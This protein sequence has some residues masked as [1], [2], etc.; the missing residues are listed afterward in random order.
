MPGLGNSAEF[1]FGNQILTGSE[2][3]P[4]FR[5]NQIL[6]T[7]LYGW[8]EI[9]DIHSREQDL[10]MTNPLYNTGDACYRNNCQRCV[11]AYEARRRGYDVHAKPYLFQLAD[12][13]PYDDGESGWP[14]V[15]ENSK[16]ECCGSND[17]ADVKYNIHNKMVSWGEGSRAIVA[18]DFL[19]GGGHVF[20]AE[21]RNGR[22]H[23]MDPQNG[24]LDCEDYFDDINTNTA[25]ILRV[26]NCSFTNRVRE[27][28]EGTRHD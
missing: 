5:Q 27:C 2:S 13:L 17:S 26:D 24:Q 22:V 21:Y 28:C 11:V 18:V 14:S 3:M 7:N 15:F 19:L 1:T 8:P 4:V 20:V 16:L 12:S 23:Y 25:S 10:A 6:A 9:D